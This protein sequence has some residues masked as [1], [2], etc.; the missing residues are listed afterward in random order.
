MHK[1]AT[2][3]NTLEDIDFVM[4]DRIR[5]YEETRLEY[6]STVAENFDPADFADY[7]ENLFT[8][9]SCTIEGNSFSVDDTRALKEHGMTLKLQNKS[10]YEAYE[11]LDHF[12]AYEYAMGN[13]DRPLTEEFLKRVHFHMTEHTIGYRLGTM[14]GEYTDTGMAS[15]NTIFGDHEENISRVPILLKSTQEAMDGDIDHPMAISAKFHFYFIYLHPF[16]DGNG[17]VGRL[18][19][20]FMLAK[21]GHPHLI[22]PAERKTKYIE[23]LT[24]SKKHRD[25]LP[26]ISFFFET[27]SD[28]MRHE[29]EQRKNR[30]QN[31]R[32]GMRQ[33][34]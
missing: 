11:I 25:F 23:S 9:H 28:R 34:M 17:R 14:P 7:N 3:G 27:A 8:A 20:N 2:F 10:L 15:G 33:K 30:F 12:K 13:P 21:K 16:R 24:A 6:Q 19:S 29:L 31:F 4:E 26:V 18:L 22:V 32:M 1:T 5:L